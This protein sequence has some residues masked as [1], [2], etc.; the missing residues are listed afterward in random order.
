MLNQRGLNEWMNKWM[1]SPAHSL[2][3]QNWLLE[4]SSWCSEDISN[5]KDP[6]QYL[7]FSRYAPKAPQV[8]YLHSQFPSIL[9]DFF[10]LSNQLP[11]SQPFL[12]ALHTSLTIPR[13]FLE[14]TIWAPEKG[15]YSV[16]WTD[17][18]YSSFFQSLI[19]WK[20]NNSYKLKVEHLK[21]IYNCE[22]CIHLNI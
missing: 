14:Y 8:P 4:S 6:N 13:E 18:L 16:P 9:T 5:S 1:V 17:N 11:G 21:I 20:E 19:K 12:E 2:G 7:N 15:D 22:F 3:L 10:S